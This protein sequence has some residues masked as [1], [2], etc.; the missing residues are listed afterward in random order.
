MW[1]YIFARNAYGSSAVILVDGLII[2]QSILGW[3]VAQVNIEMILFCRGFFRNT[4]CRTCG[5]SSS[6]QSSILF[7]ASSRGGEQSHS[8]VCVLHT[9]ELG[10]MNPWFGGS[11]MFV[12]LLQLLPGYYFLLPCTFPREAGFAPPMSNLGASR[13]MVKGSKWFVCCSIGLA[14][15]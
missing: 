8:V 15:M 14:L 13:G 6:Y 12:C 2:V 11:A 5:D 9:E 3:L 4:S 7:T 1:L 10:S